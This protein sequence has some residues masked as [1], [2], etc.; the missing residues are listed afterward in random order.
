MTWPQ[1]T[2]T[3][4]GKNVTM[5]TP[6]IISA[7]RLT[8][9]PNYYSN[10]F[11]HAIKRGYC[12]WTNPYSNKQQYISFQNTR[13]FVF[14][15]KNPKPL[16]EHLPEIDKLGFQYYFQYTLNDYVHEKLE[17]MLN[18]QDR[19]LDARIE[20]FKKLSDT[21][22]PDRV[23]WRYDPI[24]LSDTLDVDETLS[25]IRAIAKEIVP[26]TRELIFSFIDMYKHVKRNLNEHDRTLREPTMEEM[27]QLAKGIA[28]I[29]DSLSPTLKIATCAEAMDFS[30]FGIVHAKCVNPEL[31][32]R[33]C[34]K[35]S[36]LNDKK[37][38]GQRT[39][40]GCMP[41]KDIGAYNTCLNFCQYCYAS[42]VPE[43]TILKLLLN[44]QEKEYL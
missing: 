10:W 22:G 36:I 15:T 17:P 7:S 3:L 30:K 35:D 14:W 39:A 2:T 20:T 29:R 27:R 13:V 1:I 18:V 25:R 43:K 37:D 19:Y 11:M 40:C 21:I 33:L 8:D 44:S 5:I 34:G 32:A 23:I 28:E 38:V 6:S 31:I 4:D 12:S 26:Y 9:I 41:S 42:D 24:I 16:L